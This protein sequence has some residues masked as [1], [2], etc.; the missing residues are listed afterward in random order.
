MSE[1]FNSDGSHGAISWLEVAHFIF[2]AQRKLVQAKDFINFFGK[3]SS[4]WLALISMH[5]YACQRRQR[6]MCSFSANITHCIPRQTL[7]F[8]SEFILPKEKRQL[9]FSGI[10]LQNYDLFVICCIPSRIPADHYRVVNVCFSQFI[11]P[12]MEL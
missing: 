1:P 11:L 12:F 2:S 7:M 6:Q 8:K 3:S 5:P 4:V 9:I 10:K